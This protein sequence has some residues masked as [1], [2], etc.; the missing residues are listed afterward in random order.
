VTGVI[1]GDTFRANVSGRIE[2]IRVVGIDTPEVAGPYRSA[3]CFGAE[4][5]ARAKQLLNGGRVALARDSTQA[6]A[7]QFGRLL[8]AVTLAD[9]TDFGLRMISEGLAREYT[10]D[11]PHANQRAYR[12]AEAEAK[13]LGVG[14][15][16]PTACAGAAR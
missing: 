3:E 13:R 5:S 16:A 7:D 1:D 2:T 4:A 12:G 14:M 15:W 10:D 8:R 9:G 6:D 11:T